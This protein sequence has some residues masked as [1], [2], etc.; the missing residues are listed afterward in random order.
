MWILGADKARYK[1]PSYHVLA[2]CPWKS[3]IFPLRFYFFICRMVTAVFSSILAWLWKLS[4]IAKWQTLGQEM[5]FFFTS[6]FSTQE[7]SKKKITFLS[8]YLTFL[9]LYHTNQII[10]LCYIW[11]IKNSANFKKKLCNTGWNISFIS[12][13]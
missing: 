5:P 3:Y 7:S 6:V 8:K 2:L 10:Q 11:K 12:F 1:S 4:E 9:P 13:N